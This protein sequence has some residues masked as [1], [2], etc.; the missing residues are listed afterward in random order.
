MTDQDEGV[1]APNAEVRYPNL[2]QQEREFILSQ[3]KGRYGDSAEEV[4][5]RI[6]AKAFEFYE[7]RITGGASGDALSDW[8]GAQQSVFYLLMG[9]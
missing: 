9:D 2:S 7:R 1:R 8:L 6:A 4:H 5:Q 3:I